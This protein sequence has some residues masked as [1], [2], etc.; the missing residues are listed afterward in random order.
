MKHR[1]TWLSQTNTK[2]TS[3][4]ITHKYVH[5][6]TEVFSALLLVMFSAAASAASTTGPIAV[7]DFDLPDVTIISDP[8]VKSEVRP[9]DTTDNKVMGTLTVYQSHSTP[10]AADGSLDLAQIQAGAAEL[11]GVGI[12]LKRRGSSSLEHPKKGYSLDFSKKVSF[13]GMPEEK[14]WVL[15]SCWADKT[16]LRNVI[17]YWQAAKLSW[18]P[19]A[20]F[21]EVFINGNYRGLYVAIEKIKLGPNRVN[22]PALAGPYYPYFPLISGASILKRDGYDGGFDWQSSFNDPSLDPVRWWFVSPKR[23]DLD[24]VQKDYIRR[25]MDYFEA[26]FS[27]GSYY[28]PSHYEEVMDERSAADF[29]IIQELANN[30]DAYWKSMHVTKHE[31]KLFGGDNLVHMGPIWDLDLA[32]GNYDQSPLEG[33]CGTTGWRMETKFGAFFQPLKEMWKVAQFRRAIYQRW[34]ALR[35][36]ATISR[37]RIE[38]KLDAFAGRIANAR[39]RDDDKWKTLG[40]KTWVECWNRPT[41]GEEVTEL[42]KWIRSRIT[43]MDERILEGSASLPPRPGLKPPRFQNP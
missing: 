14:E 8:T 34:W 23:K 16:C 25:N 3:A 42:K 22:L 9:L 24:P 39:Y 33:L 2:A 37:T 27:P 43:W 20:E 17:G 10:L 11:R 29:V 30:V 35:S 41:F 31:L 7:L 6:V 1:L 40:D 38:N 32:F 12:E 4:V 18:A 15:H 21:V 26:Q 5:A 36:D 28:D 19:R 13:L